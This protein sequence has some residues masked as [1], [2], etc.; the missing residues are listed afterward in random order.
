MN[1]KEIRNQVIARLTSKG[2]TKIN[3]LFATP[4]PN[5]CPPTA[6][7]PK[8]NFPYTHFPIHDFPLSGSDTPYTSFSFATSPHNLPPLN[9]LLLPSTLPHTHCPHILPYLFSCIP[10][11][12]FGIS[13]SELVISMKT[14]KQFLYL[15][16]SV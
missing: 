12:L 10:L 2:N 6:S 16:K 9:I 14:G 5:L 15:P 11:H 8:K 7:P 1:Q 3:L 13:F 4:T